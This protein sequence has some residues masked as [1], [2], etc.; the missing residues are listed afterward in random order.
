MNLTR[1]LRERLRLP[2]APAVRKPVLCDMPYRRSCSADS[3]SPTKRARRWDRTVIIMGQSSHIQTP[4]LIVPVNKA[5]VLLLLM[6]NTC[7]HCWYCGTHDT[8]LRSRPKPILV[9][10]TFTIKFTFQLNVSQGF[11]P[12]VPGASRGHRSCPLFPLSTS[13]RYHHAYDSAFPPFVD[14]HRG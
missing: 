9:Y 6:T 12:G 10:L 13:L 8:A 11:P 7:K 1:R 5:I 2:R 3:N 14:S 4:L